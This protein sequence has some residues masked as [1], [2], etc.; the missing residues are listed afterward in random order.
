MDQAATAPY[1]YS[2]N[3]QNLGSSGQTGMARDRS[4]WLIVLSIREVPL[5]LQRLLG[6]NVIGMIN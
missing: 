5:T 6:L 2:K 1:K 4:F 3:A